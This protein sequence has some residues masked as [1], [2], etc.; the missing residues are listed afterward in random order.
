ME[1]V[2]EVSKEEILMVV[3]ELG[4]LK[5]LG[6]DRYNGF[7]LSKLLRGGK[8]QCA[9]GGEKLLLWWSYVKGD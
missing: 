9:K 2:K 7:F 6:L 3:F 4:A 1:L 5:A 8:R